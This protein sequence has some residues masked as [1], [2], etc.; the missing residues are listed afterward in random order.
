MI[1]IKFTKDEALL[2]NTIIFSLY[3]TGRVK[4]N[5][6]ITPTKIEAL[7][8]TIDTQLTFSDL[9]NIKLVGTLRNELH[10]LSRKYNRTLKRDCSD[11][12][13]N[14]S[15]PT[16]DDCYNAEIMD[17]LENELR[18]VAKPIT[19]DLKGREWDVQLT[20]TNNDTFRWV[21]KPSKAG[22]VR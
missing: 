6:T 19:D 21:I 14:E 10:D 16:A 4:P 8:R 5:N 11:G 12:L 13:S 3:M 9:T 2:L 22:I 17:T 18:D 20:R 15:D 1:N 7:G